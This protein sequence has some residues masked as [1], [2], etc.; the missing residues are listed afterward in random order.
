MSIVH[1]AR[2][3]NP[4]PTQPPLRCWACAEIDDWDHRMKYSL[5]VDD[6][7][8]YAYHNLAQQSW[9]HHKQ[10]IAVVGK[11]VKKM[12]ENDPAENPSAFVM[13]GCLKAMPD[14]RPKG[15]K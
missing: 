10:A 12:T 8:R 9:Y 13:S 2:P 4:E 7:A 1:R 5:G 14:Y 6:A 3:V 11:L 15:G